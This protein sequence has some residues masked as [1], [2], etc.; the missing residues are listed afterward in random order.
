MIKPSKFYILIIVLMLS[1]TLNPAAAHV[2]AAQAAASAKLP[3]KTAVNS[4]YYTIVRN[5]INTMG[6]ATDDFVYGGQGLSYA[7]LVDFDRNGVNEMVLLTSG[8]NG[9]YLLDIWGYINGKAQLLF[10]DEDRELGLVGDRS[11]KLL[12]TATASYLDYGST[13]SHGR[14]DPPYDNQAYEDETIYGLVNGKWSQME[15]FGIMWESGSDESVPERTTYSRKVNNNE[16]AISKTQYEEKLQ[17]YGIPQAE[18]LVS[19]SAGAKAYDFNT[20]NNQKTITQFVNQL[21]SGIPAATLAQLDNQLKKPTVFLT[22]EYDSVESFH[23]GLAL[24]SNAGLMGF[25]NKS[26]TEVIKPQYDYAESFSGG[27]AMA[28]KEGKYGFI[29]KQGKIVVPFKYEYASSVVNGIAAVMSDGKWGFID[30]TGK[31][32][33]KPQYKNRYS[34]SVD[35]YLFS[36]G[37]VAVPM[38]GKWG[39]I[40]SKGKTVIPFKY[41]NA[42]NFENGVAQVSLNDKRLYINKQ[43][44][45]VAEPKYTETKENPYS[46][47]LKPVQIDQL[48]GFA[49]QTGKVMIPAQYEWVRSFSEGIA[50]A[51]KN[52][53][54]ILIPNPVVSKK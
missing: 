4:A 15:S 45:A 7:R 41:T 29:N 49:D 18:T 11:L 35:A 42:Y 47:G 50:V 30:K 52:G 44:N 10:S 5:Q 1:S 6:I 40:D 37:L 36:E 26:G 20:A 38:N 3:A 33:I 31:V 48:W 8:G 24:I 39:Y 28:G 16:N 17:K 46:E 9:S 12:T 2:S 13:Y 54:W 21:K 19:S 14:G 43:G 22:P 25:I 23:E 53:K 27:L 51:H 32:I 34:N